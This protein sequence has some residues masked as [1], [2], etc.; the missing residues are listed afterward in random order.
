MFNKIAHLKRGILD[1]NAD[2]AATRDGYGVG[3]VELGEKN[4]KIVVL[5]ADLSDSTRSAGFKERFP[6]RFVQMGIAEQNMAA[7]AVGMALNGKIPFLATY[8]VFSPGR[9]WDQIRISGCYNNANVKYA[10]AHTGISVGPDGATHQAM[11]DVALT[12]VL[13]RMTVLVPGDAEETRKVTHAAA[14]INGPVYIRYSRAASPTFTTENTPFKV[15]RAQVFKE[16]TDVA[17]IGAGPIIHSALK[18][19][20]QLSE[21]GVEARVIN[22]PSI[23]PL[24][25]ETIVRAARECGAIV[26]VEEHQVMAGIGSAIAEVVVKNYP[27]PMEFIG[28][29]NSFGESGKPEE[30]LKKYR[31]DA[32]AIVAAVKKV[33]KRKK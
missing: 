33:V 23:K 16:G 17:I 3:L 27:V 28:M 13:P 9:N 11:E 12:R 20:S 15:G 30:L 29:Q 1:K 19:A 7:V 32:D 18:A 26:T 6:E 14:A 10:G 5:C 31:M 2:V 25:E 4:E 22:S 21:Q 8:A 24:D